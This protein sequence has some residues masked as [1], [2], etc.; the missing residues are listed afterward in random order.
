MDAF[1]CLK[2]CYFTSQV[3][4]SLCLGYLQTDKGERERDHE[5]MSLTSELGLRDI[6]V[7]RKDEDILS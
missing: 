7:V 1:F 5:K 4:E 2:N 6:L 3:L